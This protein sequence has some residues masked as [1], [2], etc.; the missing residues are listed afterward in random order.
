MEYEIEDK[1]ELRIPYPLSDAIKDYE[2]GVDEYYRLN[3]YE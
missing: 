3:G 1:T 2:D